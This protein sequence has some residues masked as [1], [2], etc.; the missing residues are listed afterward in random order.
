MFLEDELALKHP[1]HM[2]ITERHK[3][4]GVEIDSLT[5]IIGKGLWRLIRKT[6]EEI[7][8]NSCTGTLE[9][10]HYIIKKQSRCRTPDSLKNIGMKILNAY[11]ETVEMALGKHLPIIGREITRMA[12]DSYLGTLDS[13]EKREHVF[14]EFAKNSNRHS[15]R[16]ATAVMNLA[17][18]AIFTKMRGYDV[19]FGVQGLDVALDSIA[20]IRHDI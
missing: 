11:T 9:N 14:V 2:T 16:A 3:A 13:R 19:D 8:I 5:D 7:H 20:M 1:R 4:I 12:F 6:E 15:S 18:L 17:N 10:I